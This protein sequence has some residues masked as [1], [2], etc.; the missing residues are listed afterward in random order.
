MSRAAC[1]SALASNRQTA[2]A[3]SWQAEGAATISTAGTG[4][5]ASNRC[6]P[7]ACNLTA[8]STASSAVRCRHWRVTAVGIGARSPSS[9][10][11]TSA[12]SAPATKA[13]VVDLPTPLAPVMSNSTS[14]TIANHWLVHDSLHDDQARRRALRA[15]HDVSFEPA[16]ARS[17]SAGQ[18]TRSG[19][20]REATAERRRVPTRSPVTDLPAGGQ[21]RAQF[22]RYGSRRTFPAVLLSEL[23]AG[24]RGDEDCRK[25][26]RARHTKF[27][28]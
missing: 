13:R 6:R 25:A 4:S 5:P 21:T 1:T 18:K 14:P 10:Q 9:T 15:C 23:D 12:A 22:P 27:Q 16:A 2:I 7:D 26:G 8:R 20:G 17:S 11:S 24:H 3:S 28:W 19:D